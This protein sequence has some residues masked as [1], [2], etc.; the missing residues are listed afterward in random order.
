MATETVVA[1]L[2]NNVTTL[3]VHV[4][5][6]VTTLSTVRVPG[7]MVTSGGP[8]GAPATPTVVLLPLNLLTTT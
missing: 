6:H 8:P 7:A 4:T 3:V 1:L 2:V 5:L